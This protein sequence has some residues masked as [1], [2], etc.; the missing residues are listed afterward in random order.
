MSGS[1]NNKDFQ[2]RPWGVTISRLTAGG[3]SSSGVSKKREDVDDNPGHSA[4]C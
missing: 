2:I 4:T 1:D 3:A